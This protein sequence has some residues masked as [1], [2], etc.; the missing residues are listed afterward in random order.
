MKIEL[1]E[2]NFQSSSQNVVFLVRTENFCAT[3]KY[4]PIKPNDWSFGWGFK[5]EVRLLSVCA[6]WMNLKNT[7]LLTTFNVST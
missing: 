4:A 1:N 2:I 5:S 7:R 3:L 6:W